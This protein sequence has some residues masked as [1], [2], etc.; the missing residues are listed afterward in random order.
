MA[1]AGGSCCAARRTTTCGAAMILNRQALLLSACMQRGAPAA[2]SAGMMHDHPTIHLQQDGMDPISRAP[3]GTI[4]RSRQPPMVSAVIDPLLVHTYGLA[5]PGSASHLTNTASMG[6]PDSTGNA[7][8]A[9]LALK[10]ETSGC[11]ICP[12]HMQTCYCG[13]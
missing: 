3:I 12:S 13:W 6:R 9:W 2:P 11:V 7:T 5:Q 4:T 1:G 10:V 8:P